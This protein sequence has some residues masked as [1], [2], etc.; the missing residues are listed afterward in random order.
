[1]NKVRQ[2]YTTLVTSASQL[3]QV[4]RKPGI[5]KLWFFRPGGTRLYLAAGIV[6]LILAAGSLSQG[7]VDYFYPLDK[8]SFLISL[9]DLL[10]SPILREKE[11]LRESR[12]ILLMVFF[13]TTGLV[14]AALVLIRDLPDCIKQAERKA[15]EMVR[16]SQEV[17]ISNPLLSETLSTTAD[18]LRLQPLPRVE[19]RA[20]QDSPADIDKTRV[21]K[22]AE[23]QIRYVG[24]NQRY[25]IEKA[26]ASGG[27]GVV[28]QARDTVLERQVALKQLLEN[29]ALDQVQ[30]ERFKVEAKALALLNHP[31]ILP[32]YDLFEDNERLWLVM[33]LLTAG[34]LK[35]RIGE[36][37]MLDIAGSI[38]II[39]GISSGLGFAHQQ[40][41]VHRDIKPG[42]ILFGSDGSYR[43]TDFG[44]AKHQSN[45]TKTEAGLILGSPGYMSP[46]QAAGE[47]IDLRSD[48]YSLGIT[49]YQMIAGQLPFQ[50]DTSAVMAQHITRRAEPPSSIN[51]LV[52]EKLDAVI[53]K[54]LEKKPQDRYESMRELIG[55]LGDSD[56]V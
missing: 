19:D 26:L 52:D 4:V 8:D 41:F 53:L 9:G 11:A 22:K 29:S 25:Q 45:T 15:E 55:V 31:H 20:V 2:Y 38:D 54:M 43:I 36:S 16:Q 30:T 40:G 23:K 47:S 3:P 32:V 18:K 27:S 42:N 49:M 33:E 14:I 56:I 12:Y 10:N 21:V 48:I 44:I 13:W 28:Y 7:I 24:A 1:M 6:F 34:T 35:D 51:D 46:E 37:S 50:G 39:K 5:L 17:E